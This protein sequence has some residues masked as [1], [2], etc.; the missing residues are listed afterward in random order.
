MLPSTGI[1]VSEKDGTMVETL[2]DLHVCNNDIDYLHWHKNKSHLLNNVLPLS[3][4]N[5]HRMHSDS[6]MMPDCCS[7]EVP[8]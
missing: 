6:G 8:Q 1:C 7:H 5:S 3:S 4:G 2:E